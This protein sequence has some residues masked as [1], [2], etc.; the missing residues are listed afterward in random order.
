VQKQNILE[1]DKNIWLVYN[2]ICKGYKK[3][4]FSKVIILVL[5]IRKEKGGK[6][7]VFIDLFNFNL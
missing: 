1:V 4:I 5:F 2:K 3:F 6:N 7:N